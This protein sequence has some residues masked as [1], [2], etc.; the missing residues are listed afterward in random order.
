MRF[1]WDKAK[2]LSNQRK[3]GVRFEEASAVLLD[4]LYV[5]V[6]DRIEDG[7]P[8]WQTLDL[9]GE[10]LLLIVAHTVREVSDDGAEVEVIRIISA[11]PATVEQGRAGAVLSAAQATNHTRVDADVL[12]WLKSQGKGYQSR[13]NAILR[14][15]M[16]TSVKTAR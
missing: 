11:R 6:Q 10:L 7:E 9:V 13:I 8:R 12:N 2:N 14:R 1:E 16:L 15:E 4:P 5:S 3:H